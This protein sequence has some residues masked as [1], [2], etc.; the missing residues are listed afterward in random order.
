MTKKRNESGEGG[1]RVWKKRKANKLRAIVKYI[2][3]EKGKEEGG[4]RDISTLLL[5]VNY[6]CSTLCM[7]VSQ[8]ILTMFVGVMTLRY[9]HHSNMCCAVLITECHNSHKHCQSF[10]YVYV[11]AN[12]HT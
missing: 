5:H 11:S 9:Q 4:R 2:K 1:Q 3:S 6:A 12:K 10:D 8:R 7:Y